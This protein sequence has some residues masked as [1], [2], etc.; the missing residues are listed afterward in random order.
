M[1]TKITTTPSPL[2]VVDK[3][4]VLV[5]ESSTNATNITATK[6]T[7]ITGLS[8]SGKVITYTKGNGTTGTI[9]T[10]DT[11]YTL[12]TASSTLGGVKTTS[13]VT[14]TSGLTACPI[15]SG[16]PYYKDTNTTYTHPNSGVTAG[17]YTS[18]TVN[19]Q[20]HVTAG[21]NPASGYHTGNA[22]S[23]GGASATKPAVV[24]TTYRSGLNWYRKWSDGFIE[25]GGLVSASHE[26]TIT[27]I[28]NF[29]AT[30]YSVFLQL[31]NEVDCHWITSAYTR[32]TSNFKVSIYWTSN[33]TKGSNKPFYWYACGI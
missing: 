5:D 15:I 13:T 7:S 30:N 31:E 27:L 1:T 17:T 22:T 28:T 24:V 25:Q 6:N 26:G 20:G 19:A 2:E 32:T 12:P 4:N 29:T 14:S 21:S 8:V 11:T 3:I 9:T 23:I 33:H 16:V 18:V 10:Q